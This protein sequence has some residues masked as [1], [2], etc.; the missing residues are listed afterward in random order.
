MSFGPAS[1]P[2]TLEYRHQRPVPQN[3]GRG[4]EIRASD[5]IVGEERARRHS[6]RLDDGVLAIGVLALADLTAISAL[7]ILL[8][9]I[10]ETL[11]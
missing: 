11:P 5:R 8:A 4:P 9:W 10:T 1:R 2:M 7:L 6:F 3:A